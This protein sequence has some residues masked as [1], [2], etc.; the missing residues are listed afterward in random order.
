MVGDSILYIESCH[1]SDA[2]GDNPELLSS[3]VRPEVADE[4]LDRVVGSTYGAAF[5]EAA[6]A[7]IA[8]RGPRVAR[9]SAIWKRLPGSGV[10]WGLSAWLDILLFPE[11]VLLSVVPS[12]VVPF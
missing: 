10:C 9:P 11:E 6:L 5:V 7:T 12:R 1:V 8:V 3:F 4:V 2:S